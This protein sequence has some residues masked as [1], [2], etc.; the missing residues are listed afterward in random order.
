MEFH[1]LLHHL[2]PI[3]RE[4]LLTLVN[5]GMRTGELRYARRLCTSWL[6]I[7]PGDLQVNLL[8]AKAY[9]KDQSPDPK[10]Q[11]LPMVEELCKLDP[12][13]LEAQELLAEVS[14]AGC[15]S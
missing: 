4:L 5:T 14:N 15:H 12:E 13:F 6:A 11:A 3:S 2:T 7:Y 1:S 10:L 9:Y 8:N